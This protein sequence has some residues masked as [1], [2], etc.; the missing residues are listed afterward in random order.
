MKTVGS[1]K[2]PTHPS[3]YSNMLQF[4][5][6]LHKRDTAYTKGTTFTREELLKV[7]PKAVHDYMALKAFGKTE[8]G[9]ED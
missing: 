3:Y 1:P 5:T 8:Y 7:T 2:K 6:W 4:M 9:P